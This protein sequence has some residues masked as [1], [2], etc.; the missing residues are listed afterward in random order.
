MNVPP[1]PAVVELEVWRVLD[2]RGDVARLLA[3]FAQNPV[4]FGN[5]VIDRWR[6]AGLRVV[7]VAPRELEETRAELPAAGPLVRH[8]IAPAALWTPIARGP[9]WRGRRVLQSVEGPLALDAGAMRLL[10]RAW[11]SPPSNPAS[12][13]RPV[14]RLELV[15]QHLPLFGARDT[16]SLD[17]APDPTSLEAGFTFDRLDAEAFL[18]G[19]IALVI[20]SDAPDS[21]WSQ[22]LQDDEDSEEGTGDE[23]SS[24]KGNEPS[25]SETDESAPAGPTPP[26]IVTLGEAMLSD[27][28]TASP[29]GL[30]A[31]VVLMARPPREYRLT[32]F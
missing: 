28:A 25:D 30:R 4:P 13:P 10:A 26:A 22:W 3:P 1:E 19:S 6:S 24:E 21:D 29:R 17:P 23:E 7:A 12:D 16:F 15:V 5:D 32:G 31:V 8:S 18:D 11:T 27:W 2:Q 9:G 20:T 14:I